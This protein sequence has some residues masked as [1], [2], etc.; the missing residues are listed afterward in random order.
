MIATDITTTATNETGTAK[1]DGG[2]GLFVALDL[3]DGRAVGHQRRGAATSYALSAAHVG[4]T[5]PAGECSSICGN[6]GPRSMIAG[7]SSAA[8]VELCGGS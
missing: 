7:A 3:S 2:S 4:V 5:A 6:Q 1:T 8:S